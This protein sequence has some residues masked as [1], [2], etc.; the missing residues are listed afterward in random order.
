MS[1]SLTIG[2]LTSP[3]LGLGDTYIRREVEQ[4]RRMGHIVHTFSIRKPDASELV[5]EAIRQEHAQ[6]EFIFEAGVE[7]AGLAGLRTAIAAPRKVLRR[8]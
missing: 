6:T 4:L 3:T 5:S 8:G 1:E 2:Y 7:K